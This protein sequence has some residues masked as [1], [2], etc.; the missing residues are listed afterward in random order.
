METTV[1]NYRII[2]EKEKNR[3]FKQGYVYVTYVPTLGIS[4]FGDTIDEALKQTEEAIK[5]YVE[6]LVEENQPI[7][8]P[9]TEESFMTIQKMQFNLPKSSFTFAY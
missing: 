4:D 9:D 8:S 1:L 3:A 6:T 2:V 5:L 7:P